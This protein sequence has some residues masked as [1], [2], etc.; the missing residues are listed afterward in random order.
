MQTDLNYVRS[1]KVSRPTQEEIET[2]KKKANDRTRTS[3]CHMVEPA[4][5]TK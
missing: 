2:A 4:I 3:L 1:V 5:Y